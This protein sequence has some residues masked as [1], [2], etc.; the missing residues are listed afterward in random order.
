MV[1]NKPTYFLIVSLRKSLCGIPPSLCEKQM[2]GLRNLSLAV[3][4][5]D[6]KLHV[7]YQLIRKKSNEAKLLISY[8]P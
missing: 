1:G 5:Y 3:A 4:Q 6:K 8:Q 7:E 2:V